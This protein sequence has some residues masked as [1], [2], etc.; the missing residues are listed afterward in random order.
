MSK[1][2]I[3]VIN[4]YLF[5]F[6]SHT[7]ELSDVVALFSNDSLSLS[8]TGT[9]IPSRMEHALAAALW[10]DSDMVVGWIP[11]RIIRNTCSQFCKMH[12]FETVLLIC[13]NA[14][15]RQFKMVAEVV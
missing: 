15:T 9:D 7:L 12:E 1:T 10:N 3:V 2:T 13:Y 11:G 14:S 4:F 5:L 6:I 8:C